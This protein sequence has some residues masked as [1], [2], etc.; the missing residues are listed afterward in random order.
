MKGIGVYPG[1]FVHNTDHLVPLCQMM[2]IPI[3]CTDPWVKE[4]V[5]LF[6]PP[7]EVLLDEAPDY[8]LDGALS[9]YDTLFYIDHFRKH[10]GCF[11]F[12]QYF[13]KGNGARSVCSL[14]GNSDKKRNLHWIE[15][16]CDE[17]VTL[18][19]GQ[20]MLDFLDEKGCV[21]RLNKY[22]LSGNYRYEFYLEHEKFFDEKIEKFVFLDNNKKTILYAPTW[23][24]PHR[25]NMWRV[26]YSSFFDVYSKILKALPN[27]F[28]MIVKLHPNMLEH[29]Q[30]EVDAIK[31]S[32][33]NQDNVIFIEQM[34]LIYPLLKKVDAYLG[35][36][37]SI[38][39]D[40][41]TFNRPLFFITDGLRD[42]NQDKGVYLYHC[43]RCIGPD[44]YDKLYQII[45]HHLESDPFFEKRREIYRYAF[46]EKKERSRL[47]T[48]LEEALS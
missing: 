36:Y 10:S 6:Y 35:D 45:G 29:Y 19:Y 46:G 9:A 32:F 7:M 30:D 17:D 41:L 21:E 37:S 48:Q 34:P 28:Q 33:A 14:H 11:Q 2:G 1:P 39:Y 5:E 44:E 24:A 40:F 43:G 38:G 12:Y 31:E 47:K 20:H 22:V 26:D 13:Y 4:M 3:L 42:P 15:K 23:T 8:I 18:V 25:G 16:F 27:D